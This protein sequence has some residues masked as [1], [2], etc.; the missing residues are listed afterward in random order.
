MQVPYALHDKVNVDIEHLVSVGILKP[1]ITHLE[2][3][4][5]LVSILKANIQSIRLCEDYKAT[6]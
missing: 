2:W 1:I 4:A 3:A 5:Q 6:I